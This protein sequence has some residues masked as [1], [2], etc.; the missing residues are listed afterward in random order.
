MRLENRKYKVQE[1]SGD[2]YTLSITCSIKDL[3][4][5]KADR[6]VEVV[7]ISK[8]ANHKDWGEQNIPSLD[9]SYVDKD[10]YTKFF[11]PEEGKE[12]IY[13]DQHL[14]F[15]IPEEYSSLKEGI[16]E[17][18]EYENTCSALKDYVRNL[19][20]KEDYCAQYCGGGGDREYSF[21]YNLCEIENVLCYA[22]HEPYHGIKD[23]SLLYPLCTKRTAVIKG[24]KK[25]LNKYNWI[26]L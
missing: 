6:D 11:G 7:D 2:V 18:G 10:N 23:V 26:N 1:R 13:Y 5:L 21:I 16:Y 12:T 17:S 4:E 20:T 15:I 8:F 14:T 22:D 3:E 24:T 19:D 9:C 25:N